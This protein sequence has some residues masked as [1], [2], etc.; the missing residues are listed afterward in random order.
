ME[1]DLLV[2]T[3][4]NILHHASR[5]CVLFN[6]LHVSHINCTYL[7]GLGFSSIKLSTDLWFSP[8]SVLRRN[9]K[10]FQR[11]TDW[12][13]GGEG[14]LNG[15]LSQ[16]KSGWG[17]CFISLA[18]GAKAMRKSAWKQERHSE[19]TVYWVRRERVVWRQSRTKDSCVFTKA[20]LL[21]KSSQPLSARPRGTGVA[22]VATSLDSLRC[23][24]ILHRFWLRDHFTSW[25]DQRPDAVWYDQAL[26]P[27]VYGI[28]KGSER[29]AES[30]W[31]THDETNLNAS[32]DIICEW[33]VKKKSLQL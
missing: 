18:Q 8:D 31:N 2:F 14:A 24:H 23:H 15:L 9:D 28:Q 11:E 16:R 29:G 4:R 25:R 7:Q 32:C 27:L 3:H 19:Q 30:I 6:L 13:N 20:C 22:V 5:H 1:H 12:N 10:S 33:I 26:F 21:N 17:W